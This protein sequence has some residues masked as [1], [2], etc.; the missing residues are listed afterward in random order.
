LLCC[1]PVFP[2]QLVTSAGLCCSC[3]MAIKCNLCQDALS[4]PAMMG[5]AV[6]APALLYS[7]S[8]ILQF[9]AK[10]CVQASHHGMFNKPPSTLP[11]AVRRLS[12]IPPA[13]NSTPPLPCSR[14]RWI[15]F[16]FPPQA[17]F[18][19]P[20]IPG[21]PSQQPS[22]PAY[23]S[24]TTS[25]LRHPPPGAVSRTPTTHHAV[26]TRPAL[27]SAKPEA[28]V[29]ATLA[30]PMKPPPACAPGASLQGAVVGSSS[31]AMYRTQ[32]TFNVLGIKVGCQFVAPARIQ[33]PSPA[34]VPVQSRSTQLA[35]LLRAP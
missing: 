12:P 4:T 34:A 29:L 25:T 35:P 7:S 16:L 3:N 10:S 13:T 20:L 31:R 15:A 32:A 8:Q 18:P 11:T 17:P 27:P 14:L 26:I 24:P 6:V 23:S 5:C 33:S 19:S 1:Q 9:S 30:T 2:P 28:N 21:C 22:W